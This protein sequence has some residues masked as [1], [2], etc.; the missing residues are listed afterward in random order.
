VAGEPTSDAYVL[1]IED[2]GIGMTDEKLIAA[3]ERLERPPTIDLG[4]SRQLGLYV[5][6]KLASRHGIKVQLRHSWCG[7]LVALVKL[8]QA[9]LVGMEAATF[10]P[11]GEHGRNGSAQI[12]VPGRDA[13][14]HLPLRRHEAATHQPPL[15]A[16]ASG[17]TAGRPG[18]P[19]IATG[20][21]VWPGTSPPD[22]Q[23]RQR[24]WEDA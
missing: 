4:L 23:L 24:P 12:G 1:E 10:P 20:A 5:V 7:G 9:L 14:V 3:N 13:K 2:A 17:A 15:P 6:A 22:E 21:G 18:H 19:G 16:P 11:P 8:P